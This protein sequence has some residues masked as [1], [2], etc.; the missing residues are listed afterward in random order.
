[1]LLDASCDYVPKVREGFPQSKGRMLGSQLNPTKTP[2]TAKLISES[3][4]GGSSMSISTMWL[5]WT[6]RRQVV[7]RSWV[8]AAAVATCVPVELRLFW[9]ERIRCAYSYSY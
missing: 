1:M 7:V 8:L 6:Q 9:G 3:P 5:P 4:A 2:E